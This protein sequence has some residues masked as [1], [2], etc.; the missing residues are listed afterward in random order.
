MWGVAHKRSDVTIGWAGSCRHCYD[1][2]IVNIRL[3]GRPGRLLAGMMG[4]VCGMVCYFL[5]PARPAPSDPR[6]SVCVCKCVCAQRSPSRRDLVRHLVTATHDR[7]S[8]EMKVAATAAASATAAKR[9]ISAG[10]Q[11][12]SPVRNGWSKPCRFDVFSTKFTSI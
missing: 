12:H 5:R 3:A 7:H 1:M 2:T 6:V 4:A 10:S 8:R 9:E 11:P